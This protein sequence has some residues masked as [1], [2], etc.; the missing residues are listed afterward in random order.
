MKECLMALEVV[1][2]VNGYKDSYGYRHEINKK[3]Y[4]KKYI[5]KKYLALKKVH[6]ECK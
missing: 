4:L 2:K 5:V 6:T 1:K 3:E